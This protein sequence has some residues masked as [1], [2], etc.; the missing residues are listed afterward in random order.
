[1]WGIFL[2]NRRLRLGLFHLG[3]YRIDLGAY[4]IDLGVYLFHLG[5]YRF[6]LGVYLFNL[7][8][9]AVA[10]SGEVRARTSHCGKASVEKAHDRKND[11]I[12]AGGK[13]ARSKK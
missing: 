13:S 3:A 12:R 9:L 11:R 2:D 8:L 7:D 4:R 5:A 10:V 1:M 6:D